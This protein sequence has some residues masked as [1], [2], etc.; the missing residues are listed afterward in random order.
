[1][2]KVITLLAFAAVAGSSMAADFA[3]T[4]H[5]KTSGGSIERIQV[6]VSAPDAGQAAKIIDP[7]GHQLC[8]QAGYARATD[9]TMSSSQCS[10]K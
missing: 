9:A 6:N 2:K 7:Q 3:C 10:R 8:R 1:M 4:V 5:C